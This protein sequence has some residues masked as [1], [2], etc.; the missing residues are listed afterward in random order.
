MESV[1]GKCHCGKNNFTVSGEPEFQ[2]VCCCNSCR[3]LNGGGHLCG[4]MFDESNFTPAENA[5]T[6]SYAGGSGEP[7]LLHF[8]P[9]CATHLYGLPT[10]HPGKVVIKVNTL[11][12]YPFAPQERI[13]SE[14]AFKW[15][16]P[17]SDSH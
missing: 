10:K 1:T 11:G 3:H 8:C 9:D 17:I 16:A 2:F 15:D 13:F 6:Y 5:K 14:S 4:V 12:D 7:I